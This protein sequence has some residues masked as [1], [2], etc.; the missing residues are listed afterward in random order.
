MRIKN[1]QIILQIHLWKKKFF[2]LINENLWQFYHSYSILMF[3][4]ILT[5]IKL[6]N[7]YLKL[8]KNFCAV[9]CEAIF[10]IKKIVKLWAFCQRKEFLFLTVRLKKSALI[11]KQINKVK[12]VQRTENGGALSKILWFSVLWRYNLLTEKKFFLPCLIFFSIF[13]LYFFFCW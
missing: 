11:N 13:F 6:S 12:S 3:L 10:K 9:T 5:F 4:I 8:Y 2:F 7:L 1:G